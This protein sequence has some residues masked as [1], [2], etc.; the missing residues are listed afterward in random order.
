MKNNK[1]LKN[2]YDNWGSRIY[3]FNDNPENILINFKEAKKIGAKY[4]LS[5]NN[6]DNDQLLLACDN[7][8]KYFKLY[9]IK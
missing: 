7:C 3:A 9:K 2:Y 8:S 4:I 6:I 1:F 5:K